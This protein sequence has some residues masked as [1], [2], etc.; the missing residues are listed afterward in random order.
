M[1]NMIQSLQ[2]LVE[3]TKNEI[4]YE[5]EG[6][7]REVLD[8]QIQINQKRNELDLPDREEYIHGGFVQ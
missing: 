6:L 1:R 5:E 3:Q 7:S 4:R 8:K 2:L